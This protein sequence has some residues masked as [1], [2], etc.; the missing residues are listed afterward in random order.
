MEPGAGSR[1]AAQFRC[2]TR[3]N[4]SS[5]P[6]H[7]GLARTTQCISLARTIG[8]CGQS[9][10]HAVCRVAAND[11]HHSSAINQG[12]SVIL[13]S[14]V[15]GCGF[16]RRA[17]CMREEVSALSGSDADRA[18]RHGRAFGTNGAD[19]R[20]SGWGWEDDDCDAC[21]CSAAGVPRYCCWGE[22]GYCSNSTL[23]CDPVLLNN[24]T[25]QTAPVPLQAKPAAE[26]VGTKV[27]TTINGSQE[28]DGSCAGIMTS[29]TPRKSA[30]G[31][32]LRSGQWV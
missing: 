12:K 1:C 25:T 17:C 5:T 11:K 16:K 9:A 2:G 23:I 3:R 18:D 24:N 26:S 7:V 32:W 28:H 6:G 4:S 14:T 19:A 10:V 20:L 21:G 8:L 15:R 31:M 30:G 29:S 27:C 13:L 22:H